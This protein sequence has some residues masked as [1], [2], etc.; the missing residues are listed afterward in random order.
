MSKRLLYVDSC[1]KLSLLNF[2]CIDDDF[3]DFDSIHFIQKQ[4]AVYARVYVQYL[5]CKRW[6]VTIHRYSIICHLN[7]FIL[8]PKIFNLL[9]LFSLLPCLNLFS[10]SLFLIFIFI[11][12]SYLIFFFFFF[13]F[14]LLC[15]FRSQFFFDLL[16]YILL[17]NYC[18]NNCY[19]N[20]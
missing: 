18:Y 11:Y 15:L 14:A 9:S 19:Y 20:Y 2:G 7:L 12:S 17:L 8:I 16:L 3:Y 10:V 5:F 13:F 6:S 1:H 4:T